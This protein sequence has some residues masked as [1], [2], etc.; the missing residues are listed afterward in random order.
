MKQK[1]KAAIALSVASVM[2]CGLLS[3][4]DFVTTN[5]RKDYEQVIAEVNISKSEDFGEGGAYA[6]YK[7]AVSDEPIYKRD[8]VASFVSSGS[9]VM[10]QY[11]WTYKDTFDA[12]K[13]SLVNR[14]VYVQ[15]AK[16]YFL[17]EKV[18]GDPFTVAGY[19]AAIEGKENAVEKS[20]AGLTYFLDADEEAKALYDLRVSF[21][22]SL[23]SIEE[24]YIEAEDDTANTESVRTTPTGV[25]TEDEDYFDPDYRI[26]TGTETALGSY[27]KVDGS[28]AF[29]RREAYAAFLTNIRSSGLL[30]AGE[31]TTKIEGLGYFKRELKS[32][33]ETALIEKLADAFEEDQVAKISD[34]WVQQ[35]FDTTYKRQK[36][37]FEDG[38][39]SVDDALDGMSDTSFV[40]TAPKEGYGFVINILLPFSNEESRLLGS[41]SMDKDDVNG[42]KFVWRAN[43]LK[44]LKATDQRGT[45]FTGEENYSFLPE[46]GTKTYTGAEEADR[47]YLFFEDCLAAEETEEGKTAKYEPLKNYLGQ[48]TYNGTVKTTEK[49]GK[50]VYEPKPNKI[51]IDGFIAEMEGYLA[52]AGL[53]V[54]KGIPVAGYYEQASSDY[55][56]DM[57]KNKVDWS[58]F[59]YYQGKVNFAEGFKANDIFLEGSP[60]NKAL[61]VINE[62][63]FAYNTDTA[64]LNTYLGYAVTPYKT[65]FVSEFEY[66]AQQVCK[67]GAGNYMVVPSDYGWH[68]IYCTFSF[69]DTEKSP[70]EYVAADK[71]TEG[72]FSNLFY[73]A[74]KSA[75]V[76]KFASDKQTEIVNRYAEVSATVYEERYADLSNLDTTA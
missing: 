51:D 17:S 71:D 55:Y 15:Y 21:N 49:N 18:D 41:V 76:T 73:E 13:D 10:S 26:Y 64:G 29:T 58:K 52:Y 1:T 30:D 60:E 8:M 53:T 40:L 74:Q 12:I 5:A 19:K 36:S 31:D 22:S 42:N 65:S 39:Q 35:Q 24:G 56:V 28:S 25:N 75:A 20:I 57:N 66:A 68:I 44:G 7:D 34:E 32:A 3:G 33:Y 2:A 61:S 45:W 67:L 38:T 62:L 9:S 70:F 43:I 37:D 14:Q 72:S 23:D 27:E 4:C 50:T 47:S 6:A 16:V 11:G 48:Y 59:V 69:T 46:E 54:E 63:S